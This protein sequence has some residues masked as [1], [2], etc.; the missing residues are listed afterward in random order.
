VSEIFLIYLTTFTLIGIILFQLNEIVN[1]KNKLR[2]LEKK[3]KK[4]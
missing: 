4:S 3:E 1:L 2:M